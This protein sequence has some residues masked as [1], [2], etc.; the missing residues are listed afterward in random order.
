MSGLIGPLKWK[1]KLLV[2]RIFRIS[3][4]YKFIAAPSIRKQRMELE[5]QGR[6]LVFEAGYST[7]LYETIAEVVDHDCYQLARFK[8]SGMNDRVVLDIGANIGVS[9][10][11]L[12]NLHPG[13]IICFEPLA[14]NCAELEKNIALNGR[15]NIEIVKK[16][17]TKTNGKVAFVI[18]RDMSVGGH[19]AGP[20]GVHG[21][22]T[23]RTVE[24]DSVDFRTVMQSLGGATVELIKIDCE[25]GEYDIIDQI[26][27][28]MLP[29]INALT[30]E[31]HNLD[32]RRNAA[33]LKLRLER[34]NFNVLSQSETFDRSNLHHFL[35]LKR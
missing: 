14:Q 19:T 35:A 11:I 1:L 5:F 10:T 24:V 4:E 32:E 27:E 21:L 25:G 31:V 15:S 16:A 12:S 23:D 28:S 20:E 29:Q 6:A 26:D 17:I 33:A 22:G 3:G 8:F 2:K 9:A 13:R 30:I 18:D 34:L 7:P